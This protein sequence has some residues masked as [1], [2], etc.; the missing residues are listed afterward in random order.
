MNSTIDKIL[1]ST[2]INI[3]SSIFIYLVYYISLEFG[4]YQI[5]T[6]EYHLIHIIIFTFLFHTMK[7]YILIAYLYIKI[8]FE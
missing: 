1:D 2:L 8:K 4:I 7:M 6:I 3:L 5:L